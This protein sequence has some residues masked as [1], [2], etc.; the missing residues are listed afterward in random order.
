[1]R[2]R[3]GGRRRGR[4]WKEGTW[5][6]TWWSLF[7]PVV[8]ARPTGQRRIMASTASCL[9]C[10]LATEVALRSTL[11]TLPCI[12]RGYACREGNLG[13]ASIGC[14][15]T[16]SHDLTV[17]LNDKVRLYLLGSATIQRLIYLIYD[18]R[19][20]GH[21]EFEYAR[22]LG[23]RN[24]QLIDASSYNSQS[25]WQKITEQVHCHWR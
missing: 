21:I 14:V 12:M 22:A 20:T 25:R 16:L 23:R 17:I 10:R 24:D 5:E 11:S 3:R 13:W 8:E 18:V 6:D 7:S 9:C 1:M 19:G 2:G 4:R 15:D